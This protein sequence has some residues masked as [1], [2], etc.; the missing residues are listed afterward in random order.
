MNAVVKPPAL[1]CT[2]RLY[3]LLRMP[4]RYRAKLFQTGGSQAVR[5]PK[6]CRFPKDA[7]EVVVSRDGK[8]VV[9]EASD[10]WPPAVLDCIGRL[11]ED[12]PRLP[13]APLAARGNPFE[14]DDG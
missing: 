8:R 7:G 5:L 1:T 10:G 9:L 12:L 2:H 11:D 3:I 4:D 13:Q 6:E 14:H